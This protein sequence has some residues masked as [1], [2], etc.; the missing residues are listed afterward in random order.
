MRQDIPV[1]MEKLIQQV[2][3]TV[4]ED[5]KLLAMFKNCFTNTLNTTVKRMEDKTTYV[6]TGDIPAMWLRD[7]TAQLRPY[8]L[9]AEEDKEIGDIIEGLVRK[10]FQYILID[11]YANAFNKGPNGNGHQNDITAMSPWI[12]ER[13]YEIDSL[14]YPLQLSYLLW[15]NTGRTSHFDQEFIKVA[16]TI[17][18]LWKVEQDHENNSPYLFERKDCRPMDTLTRGGKGPLVVPTGMTWSAFRPSDD[19]CTYGYLV[20]ANMFAVVVLRYVTEIATDILGDQELAEKSSNL[21]KEIHEG[22]QKYAIVDHPKFGQVYVYETDGQGNYNFMDDANVPSLLSSPYLGY[23][24]EDDE[25]YQN[26]RRLLLSEENPFFYK[27]KF[28][29]GIGSPHTPP[30]YI[31]HIALAIQGLTCADPNYKKE[32][33]DIMQK[34]DGG[35]NLMHEGFHVDDPTRFTRDW[36]S[37]ANAMFSEL[38]LDSCGLQVKR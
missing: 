16:H 8:L 6:I 36:F 24:Q 22:I 19:A 10:Q 14:C 18:D 27:G 7:S 34:T 29:E 12:W 35:T 5:S 13:K 15:K 3:E 33:L 30:R 23:V 20:P 11:P 21:A 9:L 38:V 32:I 31:W 28:A 17:I 25:V 26:T 2:A 37:W 1:S 4:G